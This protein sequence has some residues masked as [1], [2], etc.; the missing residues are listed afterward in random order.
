MVYMREK[1][2]KFDSWDW[3]GLITVRITYHINKI[4]HLKGLSFT[5]T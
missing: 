2:T 1:V 3:G 5:L 4:L